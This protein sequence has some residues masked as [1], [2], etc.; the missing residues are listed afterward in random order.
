MGDAAGQLAHR[1][2]LLA[3][4][5][6][7]LGPFPLGGL[8]LQPFQRVFELGGPLAHLG[9]ELAGC[10][11]QRPGAGLQSVAL[12]LDLPALAVQVEEDIG[13][14]AQHV[15]LDRLLD[16]VDRAGLIAA[17]PPLG[18]GAAGGQEDDRDVAAA[19][20]AAH[21][22]GQFEA[23]HAGH[24]HVQQ[25]QRHVVLEQELQGLLAGPGLQELEAVALQ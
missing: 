10:I 21:Q 3:L 24:L 5:Q 15:R 19:L 6:R 12:G 13:L 20:V 2:H 22:L 18:V 17:E 4:A 14:A 7:R 25:R 16:E 9:L 1:L 8:G 11:G 23:V